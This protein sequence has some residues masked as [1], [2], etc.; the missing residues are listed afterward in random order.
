MFCFVFFPFLGHMFEK[1]CYRFS[2]WG[3]WTVIALLHSL[4]WDVQK[5]GDQDAGFLL[6]QTVLALICGTASALGAKEKVPFLQDFAS[7][8]LVA[9]DKSTH[10]VN[11]W[12]EFRW[13]MWRCYDWR[14]KDHENARIERP[15][16]EILYYNCCIS[17]YSS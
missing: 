11:F 2:V 16:F 14:P 17:F 3:T 13:N 9:G 4:S 8:S 6:F 15:M 12:H 7:L 10:L 5:Y 1:V